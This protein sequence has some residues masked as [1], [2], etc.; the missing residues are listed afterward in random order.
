MYILLRIN[1]AWVAYTAISNTR[2]KSPFADP[3][4]GA[5][6]DVIAYKYQP[7]FVPLLLHDSSSKVTAGQ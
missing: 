4:M 2:D 1:N 7:E 6:T 3:V 5:V